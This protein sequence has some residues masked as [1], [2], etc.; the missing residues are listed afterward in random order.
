LTTQ[1]TQEATVLEALAELSRLD[2][3]V[4]TPVLMPVE[5]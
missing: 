4:E 5:D 3:V 1:L 2:V